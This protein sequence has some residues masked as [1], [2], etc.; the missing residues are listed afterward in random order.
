MISSL[1]RLTKSP[2]PM[3]DPPSVPGP[4]SPPQLCESRLIP[5]L[6][7]DLSILCIARVPRSHHH[8]LAAVSR[9]WRTFLRSPLLFS[10]RLEVGSF[11]HFLLFKIETTPDQSRWYLLDRL[12]RNPSPPLI[13]LPEP[14]L[15]SIL[16]Y[17]VVTLGHSLFLLGGSINDKP[18]P[19]VQIYDARFNI[20]RLGAPMLASRVFATAGAIANRIYTFGGCL[21]IYESWAEEF[22]L[23]RGWRRIPSPP[24]IREKWMHGNA[25][26]GGKLLAVADRGGVVL[27][28]A[29]ASAETEEVQLKAWG[30]APATLDFGWRGKMVAVGEVLYS[31]DFRGKIRGYDLVKEEWKTVKGV[32]K[33]LPKFSYGATLSNFGEMLCLVWEGRGRSEGMEI[34]CAGIR[35]TVTNSGQLQGS[36]EWLETI[37]LAIPKGSSIVHCI[38][39]EF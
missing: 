8:C 14:P 32:D 26:I 2:R 19:V 37:D 39:V 7:D 22:N 18:S 4:S 9:T 24:M 23:E 30:T 11:Q 5:A 6:P 34:F 12:R 33:E 10:L 38:S 27:D 20:W 1:C 16:G 15:P 36:V 28:L 3:N 17:A 13:P 25:V 21:N 29:V 31:Y 35:V